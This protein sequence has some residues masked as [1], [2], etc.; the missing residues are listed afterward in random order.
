MG[1]SVEIMVRR[2]DGPTRINGQTNSFIYRQS[3][4]AYIPKWSASAH[5]MR[6]IKQII[7][8]LIS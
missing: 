2:M 5:V 3:A 7:L 4:P 8:E 6:H 1:A